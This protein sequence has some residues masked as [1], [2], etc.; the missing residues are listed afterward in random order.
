M[1]EGRWVEVRATAGHGVDEKKCV[2][3]LQQ[4]RK[5]FAGEELPTQDVVEPS[6][7]KVAIAVALMGAG[8]EQTVVAALGDWIRR[9]KNP[10]T[11]T[12]TLEGDSIEVDRPT[13]DDRERELAAFLT[14]H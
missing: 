9:R 3:S 7:G 8:A 5:E 11:V 14:T 1:G 6:D 12:L 2:K 4:L 10:G 13:F